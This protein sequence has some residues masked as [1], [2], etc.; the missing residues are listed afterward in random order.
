MTLF[1]RRPGGTA[2]AAVL[3]AAGMLLAGCSTGPNSN[4]DPGSQHPQRPQRS[5]QSS[6]SSPPPSSTTK[7]DPVTL[8]TN[9][10][11]GAANVKVDTLVKVNATNGEISSVSVS[12]PV[13]DRSGKTVTVDVPGDLNGDKTSWTATDRLEPGAS[14]TLVTSAKN[15]QGNITK[16]STKF[17]TEQLTL[18]EQTF[19]TI[20]PS[21]SS[22][23]GIAMPVIIKFDLPVTDKAAFER[24]LHV[25][26]SPAQTGTWSWYSSREV[27]YRPEKYWMPG[28]KIKVDADING[29]DAGNGVYGQS[30]VSSTFSIGDSHQIDVDLKSLKMKVTVN[31]KVV[32]TFPVSG[33]KP[34]TETRSTVLP[35]MQKLKVTQMTSASINIPKNQESFSLRVPWAMKLTNSGE[36]VHAN[37]WGTKSIGKYNS[38]HA[39][40]GLFTKD[41]K[42][43]FALVKVGDPVTVTGTKRVGVEKGNGWTDWAVSY[44]DFAKGSAL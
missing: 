23:F 33:G 10:Q 14:Y 19:A 30:A 17:A 34:G 22:T 24:H 26:S 9:V 41:A 37:W 27:H 13:Q 4:G 16:V 5:S 18:D 7:S 38:S 12:A 15:A 39:C 11:D 20:T 29:L 8:T 36:F 1:S 21:T 43:L 40:V 25:T 2:V 35:I 31:G 32:H 6:T 42:W 3:L 28:T 44:Q